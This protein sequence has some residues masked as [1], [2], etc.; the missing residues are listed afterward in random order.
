MWLQ[1]SKSLKCLILMKTTLNAV[2][3][4]CSSSSKSELCFFLEWYRISI[5]AKRKKRKQGSVRV[6]NLNGETGSK[7]GRELPQ[8]FPRVTLA[9]DTMFAPGLKEGVLPIEVS[10]L[11]TR[12]LGVNQPTMTRHANVD[13]VPPG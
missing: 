1:V 7:S 9:K 8:G 4:L 12:R 13:R 11:T 10:L 5:K 3:L 2:I 6:P